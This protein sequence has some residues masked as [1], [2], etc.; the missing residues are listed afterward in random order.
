MVPPTK[1]SFNR[2]AC[3]P[4]ACLPTSRKVTGVKAL[5]DGNGVPNAAL[6]DVTNSEAIAL[7]LASDN[8]T[9]LSATESVPAPVT[10]V[11][12]RHRK[13][14]PSA[15]LEHSYTTILISV[16]TSSG[17]GADENH[18]STEGRTRVAGR[19]PEP[20]LRRVVEGAAEAAHTAA[21]VSY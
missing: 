6:E 9:S 18:P 15:L 3:T 14:I 2:E 16:P 7:P 13:Y 8:P 12:L 17:P 1:T 20:T 10:P 21:D 5:F 19:T 11:R 4:R